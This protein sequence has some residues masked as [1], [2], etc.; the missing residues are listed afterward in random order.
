MRLKWQNIIVLFFLILLIVLIVKSHLIEFCSQS[1]EAM[2]YRAH[3]PLYGLTFFGI[4]CITVVGIIAI[5]S[6][7]KR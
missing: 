5:I 1:I 6:N 4:I 7:R 2:R 3:D